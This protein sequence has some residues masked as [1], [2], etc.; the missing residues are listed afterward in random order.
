VG[1]EGAA[2]GGGPG[3]PRIAGCPVFPASNAW[4]R[5][6]SRAPV[7]PRSDA[8]VRSLSAGG[9]RFLH[10]D[11]G[12]NGGAPTAQPLAGIPY[13]VVPRTQRRVP[14]R[15]TDYGDESDRG[16]YPIPLN[17]PVERG[18]DRHVLVVQRG[19]C[20]L[21][22]LF[23]AFRSGGGWAASSGAVFDLRSNRLR[24][25]GYTSADAAGMPIFPGLARYD[26]V[27]AGAIQHA[28]RFTVSRTQRGYVHPARHFASSRTDPSLPPMG[29]RLRLKRSFN[30]RAYRGQA[31]VVL[32]A[33]KRYGMF[34]ADN[35]SDWFI[36]G[37]SDTRWNDN[38]LNQLKRVP[39][40]A[41]EVVR[42]GRIQR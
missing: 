33:L 3:G 4:N 29:L 39:G 28:L 2:R 18:G 11:F 1:G 35:G 9:D 36:T 30:T 34:V 12:G 23:S 6:V 10:A 22:E 14:I 7:D 41:F 5:D 42:H 24:P 32:E 26:E 27:R 19:T 8:Y 38:D 31:R 15:F 21:F 17:A 20:R 37:A 13:R 40:A 16:P 25:A